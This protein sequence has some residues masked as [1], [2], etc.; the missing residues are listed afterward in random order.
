L[1]GAQGN[2]TALV[3]TAEQGQAF[4]LASGD[5]L[6]RTTLGAQYVGVVRAPSGR[7]D[8]PAAPSGLLSC[9]AGTTGFCAPGALTQFTLAGV[10]APIG[11]LSAS[12][13]WVRGDAVAGLAG[14]LPGQSLLSSPAGFG[15][16]ETDARDAWQFTAGITGSLARVTT[17]LH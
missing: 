16:G 5:N 17:N 1:T 12:A 9:V 3:G 10:N 6:V 11:T 8:Q 7:V 4:V 15:D 2:S 13:P 14:S